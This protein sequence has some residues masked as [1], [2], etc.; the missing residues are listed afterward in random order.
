MTV[1]DI[2]LDN[3]GITFEGYSQSVD[4]FQCQ[5]RRNATDRRDRVGITG[6][7]VKTASLT[8]INISPTGW[9]KHV[10]AQYPE[11][12]DSQNTVEP[13]IRGRRV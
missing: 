1:E 4:G 6:A 9:V 13:D 5:A 2:T 11:F 7:H 12:I 3:L 10:S 8:S